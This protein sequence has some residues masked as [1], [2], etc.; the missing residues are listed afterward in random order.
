MSKTIAITPSWYW[1]A[2]VPRVVGVPP[3]A[4][5]ELAVERWARRAPGELALVDASTRLTRGDLANEVSTRA[6]A[7]AGRG[8]VTIPASSSAD[9]AVDLLA[10]LAAGSRV[11][12]HDATDASAGSATAALAVAGRSGPVWFSQRALLAGALGLGSFYGLRPEGAWV[13]T[14]PLSSWQGVQGLLAPLLAG[15]TVV[16]AEPGE[17]ALDAIRREGASW[18]FAG[19]DAA[20]EWTRDA[21]RE[22]KALRGLLG[23]ALLVVDGPFDAE[24]RRRVGRMLECPALTLFGTPEAG[25][26]FASHPSWYLDEAVGIPLTN[27]HVVPSDPRTGTPISTLWELVESAM[28][29]V[30]GPSVA[31]PGD[32]GLVRLPDGRLMTGVIASSDPNGM[33]YLLPS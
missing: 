5:H 30:S 28:V 9:A 33:V 25:P 8:D 26:I 29:T 24:A 1:P 16:V 7:R 31:E 6:A 27:V 10:A 18:L 17:P 13:T 22:V 4:V 21:K 20:F 11:H 14:L 23:S 32:G 3:F 12:A 19:L 15:L 2:G